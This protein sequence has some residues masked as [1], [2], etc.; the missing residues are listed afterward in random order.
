MPV[1]NYPAMGFL[2]NG[3]VKCIYFQDCLKR[4]YYGTS[5]GKVG[6]FQT[7]WC[8]CHV[9]MMNGIREAVLFKNLYHKISELYKGLKNHTCEENELGS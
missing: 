1:Q 9:C 8:Y 6:L 2:C 3:A 5:T 7:F 4:G